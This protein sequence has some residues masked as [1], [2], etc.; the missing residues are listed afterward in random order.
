MLVFTNKSKI[1]AHISS[2]K[3]EGETIGF[4]PTMGALHQGHLSLVKEGLANN[5]RLVV[6]IFVNPTQ[7]DNADDLAKY[8]RTLEDDI[9]LL[10]TVSNKIIVYAPTVDD[11]YD[12]NTKAQQFSFDGLEF[13]MEGKFRAG[14]FDG[15]GTIVKRLFEI[16]TPNNAYFGEK[17]F[18][19]LAIIKKLV[20]KYHLPVTIVGC[21]IFREISGLAMSSRNV[22]LKPD[23]KQAAPFIYKTLKEAK[24]KFGTKSADKTTKWVQQQF[25]KHELL[26]LEY[27]IIADVDT[28]KTVKRKNKTNT[29]RAFIAVYADD[30]RLIDN[31]ALN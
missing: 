8:P 9:A 26:Q 5:S 14:H 23:Y 3:Q 11:I 31:I 21:D 15:V 2:L 1:G 7:F 13:E 30:I 25:D 24:V 10:K 18:Q 17:D 4:V 12:G 16:V 20:S 28:L 27:F 6:S 19:Q 29:Y 22:R